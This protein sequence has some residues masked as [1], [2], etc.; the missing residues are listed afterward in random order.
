M[1]LGATRPR[2]HGGIRDLLLPMPIDRS[3]INMLLWVFRNIPITIVIFIVA[4]FALLGV[5]F[6][7]EYEAGI[8]LIAWGSLFIIVVGLR[9]TLIAYRIFTKN[10][11]AVTG[12][13]IPMEQIMLLWIAVSTTVA[14]L[15]FIDSTPLK[16]HFITH[17][18]FKAGANPF[19]VWWYITVASITVLTGTGYSSIVENDIASATIFGVGIAIA[20]YAVAIILAYFVTFW[21]ELRSEEEREE[22]ERKMYAYGRVSSPRPMGVPR[23]RQDKSV[24]GRNIRQ[25]EARLYKR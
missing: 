15:Y 11:P 20:Y 14:G 1:E 3:P 8:T 21:S 17:A 24:M 23:N 9:F 7:H 12:I 22:R 10:T 19:F 2:F 16:D 5:A 18:G 6:P 25:R 4:T 13:L